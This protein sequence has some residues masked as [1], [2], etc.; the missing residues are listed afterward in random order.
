LNRTT[1]IGVPV[2]LSE[3]N[4]EKKLPQGVVF[5]NKRKNCSTNF[6]VL[7]LHAAI[8]PQRL[9][10][11]RNSPPKMPSSFHFTAKLL[12]DI[13]VTNY[14]DITRRLN[15]NRNEQIGRLMGRI[16]TVVGVTMATV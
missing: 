9:L 11:V 14:F 13:I 16:E 2:K 15:Y 12:N 1:S 5:T 7:R 10:I 6:Q 8:T 3:Q 4:F